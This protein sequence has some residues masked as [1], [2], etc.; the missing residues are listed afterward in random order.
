M[1]SAAKI[2]KFNKPI[3]KSLKTFLLW[4]EEEFIGY[5]EENGLVIK[6]WCKVCARNKFAI[7]SDRL[8]RGV[9]VGSLKAFIEGTS[10][11]TKHQV[12][13]HLEGHIH[14]L[15]LEIDKRNPTEET[16]IG[17]IINP[18]NQN[19][20]YNKQ[21][22]REAY[23]KMIK[24]AYEMA[25]KP[26]MP[27][28]HFEVLIKCQRLNGVQLVEGKGHNRAARQFISCIANAIKEKIAK[29]VK[30]KNFF[31]ILSDGSQARK[32]KD[33]K[34]LVL[35]RVERD[36]IPAYL[37]VSLLEMNSLDGVNAN[38]IKKGIDSIF[39]ESGNIPL[40]ADAY[41][42]KLVSATSDGASVNL[43]MYNGVLTQMKNNR[44]WLV[45]M[46]CVNHRLEL[47]IKDSARNIVQYRDCDQFYTTIFHLFRN[48][49]KLKSEV[50]K[51]AEA[52]NI[53]YYT[54][55]KISGTRFVSHRRRGLTRL[56]HNWPAIIVGFDNAL[57]NRNTTAEMRAKLFGISKRLHDYRLLCM[58]C[59]YLDVLEK[60]SPLSLVFEK[61]TLM[62]HEVKPAID[63]TKDYLVELSNETIDDILD[64]YL[65]K[66]RIKYKD[67]TTTLVSSY[68]KDGHELKKT[69]AE[70]VDIELY[71]M[72]NINIDSINAAI[73]VR[74]T[75]VNII[76][77]LID[78]RFSS[79]SNTVFESMSW[80]DPQFW[81]ADNMYG[82][83]SI[84]LLIREFKIPLEY[85]GLKVEMV[86]S[87]WNAFKLLINTEYKGVTT[88]L[89]WEKIFVYY[90]KTFPNLLLL[91]ELIMC[92]SCS[93]SSVER[94][95][96]ILTL[97]LSDRRLKMSNQ[98]MEDAIL[99]AGNDPNF[100][101]EERDDILNSA[102]N[103]YLNKRRGV[104]LESM[105]GTDAALETIDSSDESSI[106][107]EY[108]STS[109][110]DY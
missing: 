32:T 3:S 10:V 109:E 47:A 69:N 28:S 92:I 15:A 24:T 51:A 99:I 106:D 46:H 97:I 71:D 93:N 53:T 68:F 63:L 7:L 39:N 88:A 1:A 29:I 42:N 76:K 56:V 27:H 26:S 37:V 83:A 98:T 30:E 48:S 2:I 5:T 87:E 70:F 104:R 62:V 45:K 61:K 94:I 40:T 13:R 55:P 18:D 84:S 19:S 67:D 77:P 80:L 59:G 25:L 38:T 65:L 23:F 108:S 75:A 31:S 64:S 20:L 9:M 43:G 73:E 110:S 8:V 107:D 78:D 86:L 36:G 89:L 60:L 6:I 91:V 44:T 74:K 16:G 4:G 57:V 14:K 103:I 41:K 105:E 17:H 85:A 81:T 50:K 95:F 34:E 102:L 33:E 49:G 22:I 21:N 72:T 79:L 58:F 90:R 96:S 52:L 100:T 11:V 66:F 101:V 54:L 82:D 35:V 12:D